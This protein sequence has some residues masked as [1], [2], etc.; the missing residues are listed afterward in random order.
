MEMKELLQKIKGT[1]TENSGTCV[2]RSGSM[3]KLINLS[4]ED[5]DEIDVIPKGKHQIHLGKTGC[6][7]SASGNTIIS[8]NVFES[9]VSQ[10]KPTV[11]IGREISVIDTPETHLS[12]F[13]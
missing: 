1:R 9:T 10:T 11:R 2:K 7:E 6:E 12:E 5:P 8:R 13:G 3:D 4:G